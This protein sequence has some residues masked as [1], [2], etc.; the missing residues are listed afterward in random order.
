MEKVSLF[1]IVTDHKQNMIG[2]KMKSSRRDPG[3]LRGP[4][5]EL[6]K[7]QEGMGKLGFS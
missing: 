6:Q 4:L 2:Q 1:E 5:E 3:A 7:L